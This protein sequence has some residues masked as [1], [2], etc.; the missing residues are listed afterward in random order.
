MILNREDNILET[1]LSYL[2]KFREQQLERQCFKKKVRNYRM[3]NVED[4]VLTRLANEDGFES[5][6]SFRVGNLSEQNCEE[7]LYLLI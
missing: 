7:H 3:L 2:S 1:K 4:F 6:L 5:S